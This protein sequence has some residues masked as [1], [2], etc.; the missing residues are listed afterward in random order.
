MNRL[1]GVYVDEVNP[2][3]QLAF[4]DYLLDFSLST[5]G[6]GATQ[7]DGTGAG[8]R[9]SRKNGGALILTAGPETLYIVGKDIRI[10]YKLKDPK[11]GQYAATESVEEGSFVNNQWVPGRRIN[12]DET[13]FV[14]FSKV[15]AI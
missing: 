8:F 3:M 11:T 13:Y 15:K 5:S 10:A 9:K 1:R 12:G 2:K 4:G 6:T 14:N 7:N